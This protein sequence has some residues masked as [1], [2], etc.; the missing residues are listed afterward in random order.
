M[1]VEEELQKAL[2]AM[3]AGSKPRVQAKEAATFLTWWA[4]GKH[5]GLA[6]LITSQSSLLKEALWSGVSDRELR[7]RGPLE[8]GESSK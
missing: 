8:G 7:K 1:K 4:L 2:L 3:S 5:P 6:S